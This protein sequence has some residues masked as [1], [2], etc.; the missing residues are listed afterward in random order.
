[1][2]LGCQFSELLRKQEPR[3]GNP[4]YPGFLVPQEHIIF[5]FPAPWLNVDTP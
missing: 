2:F 5:E 4:G 3:V 1:M